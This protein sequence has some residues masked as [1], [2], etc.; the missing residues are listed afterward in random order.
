MP[1]DA[2]SQPG[3]SVFEGEGNGGCW[4]AS[5][6]DLA[7][8]AASFRDGT[9]LD[10]NTVQMMEDEVMAWYPWPEGTTDYYQ[11]NGGLCSTFTSAYLPSRTIQAPSTLAA[12]GT[13]LHTAAS[14][15]TAP[16]PGKCP[17]SRNDVSDGPL[18]PVPR[19]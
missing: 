15:A 2:F 19:R 7:R 18:R 17:Q 6:I 11:K 8:L 16:W 3:D 10:P 1:G 5:A 14:A 12:T 9:I 13:L 4:Y